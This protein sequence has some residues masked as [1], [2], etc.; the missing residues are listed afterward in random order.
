MVK[1][2]FFLFSVSRDR[3]SAFRTSFYCNDVGTY[4]N[5]VC[6]FIGLQTCGLGAG[7]FIKVVYG[8]SH[9]ISFTSTRKYK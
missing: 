5:Y 8:P 3:P 7:V 4:C 1:M 9:V 2:V 6:H